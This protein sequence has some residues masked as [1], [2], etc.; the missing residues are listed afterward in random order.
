MR[1]G[2]T[3]QAMR[4]SAAMNTMSGN[5]RRLAMHQATLA[6]NSN[7]VGAAIGVGMVGGMVNFYKEAADFNYM[8][9]YVG[10]L[11]DE[12]GKS[13]DKL[14][15]KAIEV[16]KSSTFSPD[17]VASGMRWMAQSGMKAVDII[18]S[19][20]SAA[21]LAQATM[22]DIGGRGG[23]ADWIT[24]IAMGFDI[25]LVEKNIYR[26]SNVLAKGAN[27]SN[28][29]LQ[30]F[31]EAMKYTQST[32]KRLHMTLEE[33]A[34]GVMIMANMGIQGSMAGTGMENM[35]RYATRAA[36]A[37]DGSK[38]AKALNA[39]GLDQASLKDAKGGLLP[40][41]VLLDKIYA[42]I[43]KLG[44]VDAQN[45][46]VDIFG[47]RGARAVA[48][49]THIKKYNEYL[50]QLQNNDNYLN[51]TAAEMM[52][53]DKGAMMVLADTWKSFKIEFGTAIAPALTLLI[54]G[55]TKVVSLVTTIVATPI[56]KFLAMGISGFIVLK[57]AVM[58]Y[59]AI[60]LTINILQAQTGMSMASMASGSVTG[61]TR[62]TSAAS[63]Y[64]SVLTRIRMLTG[65]AMSGVGSVGRYSHGGYYQ[66]GPG[67]GY[68]PLAK[69]S[70]KIGMSKLNNFMG[71]ASI[72]MMLASMGMG[73]MA[74]SYD[75]K[76]KTAGGAAW[77]TAG[78]TLMG[79][80]TGAMIGSIIPGIGTAIGGIVGGT[81]GLL[82]GL[83]TRLGELNDEIKSKEDEVAGATMAETVKW[84]RQVQLYGGLDTKQRNWIEDRYNSS[85]SMMKDSKGNPL[86]KF[87]QERDNTIIIQLNGDTVY[88]K[89]VVGRD[90]KE[91]VNLGLN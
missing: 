70:A 14:K 89:K 35:L 90:V 28:T 3:A 84:K 4:A 34:A 40:I 24:N 23:S 88:N 5:A 25:P 27:K 21:K 1:D 74:D 50:A 42:G 68:I 61:Y 85:G 55:L 13:F 37:K 87:F 33:T 12:T 52:N 78:D 65:G 66:I 11:S 76:G 17:E 31:G 8:I 44:T 80:S 56:G 2:F 91:M 77:G 67:G 9:K 36:G 41:G 49:G 7:L 73:Y 26:L 20:D 38:Q 81:I 16:G 19:I 83:R 82:T 22:T 29:T 46:I 54:K 45:A 63:G 30:E 51:K 43:A 86:E 60:V 53:T 57:T 15:Q 72:P 32:A 18:E 48:I 69:G 62:M 75:S 64:A 10:T 39:I 58:G 59:R 71:K 79:A 47:V 6:R